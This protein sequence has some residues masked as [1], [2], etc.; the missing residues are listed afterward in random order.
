MSAHDLVVDG[1]TLHTCVD[2]V[3]DVS[4]GQEAYCHLS[5]AIVFVAGVE[6]PLVEIA[7]QDWRVLADVASHRQSL[8]VERSLAR[9]LARAILQITGESDEPSERGPMKE[10]MYDETGAFVG[11]GPL[12]SGVER[13]PSRGAPA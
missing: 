11:L 4:I 12:V 1:V 9:R 5:Q 13:P 8:I 3:I 2:S 6:A 7:F 10:C